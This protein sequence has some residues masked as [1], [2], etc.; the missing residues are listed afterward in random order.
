MMLERLRD[1]IRPISVAA[2][3][4]MLLLGAVISGVLEAF[5]PGV[6]VRFTEGV[7]GW[8]KAIPTNYYQLTGGLAGVYFV[9]RE[10]GKGVR[11]WTAKKPVQIDEP[12]G[13]A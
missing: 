3:L 4:A 1:F 10:A 6:G 9:A 12:I 11:N 5:L 2:L 13:G 8:F 7:A